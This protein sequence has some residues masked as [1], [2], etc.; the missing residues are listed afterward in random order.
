MPDR[1][2]EQ[3]HRCAKT[4]WS[5]QSTGLIGPAPLVLSL[6]RD[7]PLGKRFRL[8][9]LV[10]DRYPAL[11]RSAVPA[12]CDALL[13]APDGGELLAE[14]GREGHAD[15]LRFASAA[16]VGAISRLLA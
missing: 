12:P 7:G 16:G 8:E 2:A 15:R 3:D 13:G 6:L 9:S 4:P 1:C 10:R 11:H 14:V 5:E